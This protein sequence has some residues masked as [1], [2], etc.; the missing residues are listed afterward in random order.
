MNISVNVKSAGFILKYSSIFV[1][2]CA[3]H[4]TMLVLELSL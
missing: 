3:V 1:V 4:F 2:I